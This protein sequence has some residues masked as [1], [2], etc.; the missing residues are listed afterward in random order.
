MMTM[1]MMMMKMM[2]P[3]ASLLIN[4]IFF[5]RSPFVWFWSWVWDRERFAVF[6]VC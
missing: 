6:A 2:T 1:M 3:L 4:S 5:F